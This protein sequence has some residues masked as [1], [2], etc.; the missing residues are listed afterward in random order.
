MRAVPGYLE[1]SPTHLDTGVSQLDQLSSLVASRLDFRIPTAPL[2]FGQQVQS[3]RPMPE[4][5][6]VLATGDH[7]VIRR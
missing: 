5:L 6:V 3:I 4:G 2:P 1:V 7:V